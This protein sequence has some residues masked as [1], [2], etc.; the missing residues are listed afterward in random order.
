[1]N[2]K[3]F[4]AALLIGVSQFISSVR[5]DDTTNLTVN[6]YASFVVQKTNQSD[7]YYAPGYLYVTP[8]QLIDNKGIAPNRWDTAGTNAGI[9]LDFQLSP[10]STF[11]TQ[12]VAKGSNSWAVQTDWSYFSYKFTPSV[13]F[14]AGRMRSPM[15]MYSDSQDIGFSYSWVKPPSEM[16]QDLIPSYDGL[17]LTNRFYVDKVAGNVS[18]SGGTLH[19][20][21]GHGALPYFLDLKN[22]AGLSGNIYYGSLSWFASYS[23]VT[24]IPNDFNTELYSALQYLADETGKFDYERVRNTRDE[25]A[26]F[27][28]IGV[29]YNDGS[30]LII[31]ETGTLV[32][33]QSPSPSFRASL[34]TIGY[35][36]G[37]FLPYYSGAFIKTLP[38]SD[39]LMSDISAAVKEVDSRPGM[40]GVFTPILALEKLVFQELGQSIGIRYDITPT[41][42]LKFEYKR[43]SHLEGTNGLFFPDPP[44]NNATIIGFSIDTIF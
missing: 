29:T 14:K 15:F 17:Q 19:Q 36:F 43:I 9:Q 26:M 21:K 22:M 35:R 8:D 6:G 41:V 7:V 40:S 16:Y 34:W 44:K 20:N 32:I 30:L 4:S 1:M 25:H 24:V 37:N 3:R 10:E 28:D 39:N 33:Y 27:N 23:V 13:I 18:L 31:A 12:L 2:V 5:A 11:T 42:D 38:I